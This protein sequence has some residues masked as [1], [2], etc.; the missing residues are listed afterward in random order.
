MPNPSPARRCREARLSTSSSTH[1]LH[2]M[3]KPTHSRTALALATLALVAACGGESSAPMSA[4]EFAAA[5]RPDAPRSDRLRALA[6]GSG[7]TAAAAATITNEQLFQWARLT[8]P[9]LFPGTPSTLTVPYEGKV[10][11]VRAFPNGNYLGVSNGVAY[12]LGSFTGGNLQDFGSVQTYADMV[13]SKVSCTPTGG[14]GGGTGSLNGCTQGFSEAMRTGNTYRVVYISSVLV[15]PSSTGEY[16][17]DGVVN[18]PSSFEG[19]SATKVTTTTRGS[20]FGVPVDATILSYHV[21]TGN[22][23]TRTLGTEATATIQ[24]FPAS[25]KAVFAA[26]ASVN[27]EFTLAT[28]TSLTK[29]E[30]M[31]ST[32]SVQGL[33]F[34]IPPSTVTSSTTYTYEGR[35]TVSVQGRTWDTCRYRS[36]TAD[37]PGYTLSWFIYGKGLAAKIEDYTAGG[38]VQ[39]RGELKSATMNGASL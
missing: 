21:S 32:T 29:S 33:P 28:G 6:A 31:T 25:I 34:P 9:E 4:Q 26:P 14:G 15:A 8:Y 10:F 3:S 38:T 17:I 19:T 16:T 18:G 39:Y 23:L 7:S 12:G 35:D 24:G 1:R 11:D 22:D 5:V 20:Q 36:T 13:C 2:T 30:T 27:D 37:S